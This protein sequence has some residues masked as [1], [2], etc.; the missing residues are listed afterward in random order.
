MKKRTLSL[1]IAVIMMLSMSFSA[2]AATFTDV[3]E[4]F[5]LELY[6]SVRKI[7]YM[8]GENFSDFEFARDFVLWWINYAANLV[9]DEIL[10]EFIETM[11]EDAK[12]PEYV[13]DILNAFC[14][15]VDPNAIGQINLTYEAWLLDRYGADFCV[16]D[17]I[18]D[19]F[20]E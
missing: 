15:T 4:N 20:E 19:D 14:G 9:C 2:M 1:L 8:L 11:Y 16:E 5:K 3:E 12:V 10:K 18:E 13:R 17:A 6:R 7:A